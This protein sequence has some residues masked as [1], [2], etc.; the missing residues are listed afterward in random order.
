MA[1]VEL[2]VT[3]QHVTANQSRV[4]FDLPVA[5]VVRFT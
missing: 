2:D 5:G 1:N 4:Y 3:V